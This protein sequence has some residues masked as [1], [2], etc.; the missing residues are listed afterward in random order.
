MDLHWI[1]GECHCQCTRCMPIINNIL[2]YISYITGNS[3]KHV[4]SVAI[5]IWFLYEDCMTIRIES[6]T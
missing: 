3:C 5:S 1:P 2:G 4:V 6:L